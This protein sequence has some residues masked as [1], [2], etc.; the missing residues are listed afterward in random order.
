MA[1]GTIY[2]DGDTSTDCT[3]A[4]NWTVGT[5]TAHT[6]P[7]I[8]DEVIF[9]GRT[10]AF[11]AITVCAVGDTGG[12]DYDLLHAKKGHTGNIGTTDAPFHTS[13]Q[14]III[15]GSGT[16]YLE[17]S[18]DAASKDQ[19][20]PLVIINNPSA[21][22][23]LTS[24][25]NTSSWCCEFTDIIVL[26][27]TVYIGN[28]GTTD[29]DTAVQ[30]LRVSPRNNK[31]SNVAVTIKE[32]CERLKATT[33]K[34]SIYMSNGTLTTDSAAT[35]IDMRN[36]TL[37]YGTDLVASP[38]TGMDI[39]TLRLH[40]GTF[41]WYPDDSDDDA[42]IGDAYLFGGT[43]NANAATNNDQSKVL[44]NGAGNDIFVFEGATLNI[45]NGM[46]NITIAASSQLWNFGG[47]ITTDNG[48][49]IAVSYDLP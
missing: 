16:Y 47:T 42:Y 46:G 24:N 31:S 30:Y 22:V 10:N 32:D 25:E 36:G 39:T 1:A 34:M 26:A 45:A 20:I 21:T 27:G 9:D 3:A 8:G 23:Y 28:N 17:C 40:G 49:Q 41:N 43:L 11:D 29:V 7:E 18:E 48:T 5:A 13:A 6:T 12:V 33:Y 15:E 2:W 19:I 37:N 35:L 4:A 14:K 44:G 38:E